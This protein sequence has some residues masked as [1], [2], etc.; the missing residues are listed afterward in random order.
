MIHFRRD[1]DPVGTWQRQLLLRAES[2]AE[3]ARLWDARS[4]QELSRFEGYAGYLVD[5]V[6][7]PDG[8]RLLTGSYDNIARLWDVRTGKELRHVTP[9]LRWGQ[10]IASRT[11]GHSGAQ[12]SLFAFSSDGT[13]FI[14]ALGDEAVIVPSSD[15][16]YLSRACDHL[17]VRNPPP[18]V[19]I[20]RPDFDQAQQICATVPPLTH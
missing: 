16:A 10:S 5:A 8:E 1:R 6:F 20:S 18:R 13:H 3:K 2:D 9:R 4:G 17:R 15:V 12:R 14:A 19:D 11:D 7:S